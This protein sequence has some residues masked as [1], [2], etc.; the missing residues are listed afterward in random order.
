MLQTFE[1]EKFG[2]LR[3]YVPE[4]WAKPGVGDNALIT[5][6]LKFGRYI[7]WGNKCVKMIGHNFNYLRDMGSL[8]ESPQVFHFCITNK[9]TLL[10][11]CDK[12]NHHMQIMT[13]NLGTI[14]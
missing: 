5:D 3:G 9:L 2:K 13:G 1:T 7:S 14:N 4:N 6:L 11:Y 8:R 12:W 10:C